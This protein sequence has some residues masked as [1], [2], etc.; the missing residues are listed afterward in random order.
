MPGNVLKQIK[1]TWWLSRPN[2]IVATP[3]TEFAAL[4]KKAS[5]L[6]RAPS[7]GILDALKQKNDFLAVAERMA[8]TFYKPM[9][10]KIYWPIPLLDI[11]LA[12]NG[13]KHG[14][15]FFSP[16]SAFYVVR[17]RKKPPESSTFWLV[18]PR[19]NRN[20]PMLMKK[21]FYYVIRSWFVEVHI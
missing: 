7:Q 13:H 9:L 10:I 2:F 19:K 8:S 6:I 4:K 11:A 16:P 14:R 17:V 20:Q 5:G 12:Q 15:G 18:L 3:P 1:E 21:Q